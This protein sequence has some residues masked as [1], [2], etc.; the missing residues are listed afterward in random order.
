MINYYYFDCVEIG[1]VRECMK[2]DD[3]VLDCDLEM[4]EHIMKHIKEN[5][6]D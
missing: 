3:W 4:G 2:C 1:G 6:D 5:R